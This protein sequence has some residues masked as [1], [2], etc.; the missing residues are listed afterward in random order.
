[1]KHLAAF[2]LASF[3]GVAGCSAQSAEV[4]PPS[5]GLAPGT[6]TDPLAAFGAEV[7]PC[8]RLQLDGFPTNITRPSL[9]Y[10]QGPWCARINTAQVYVWAYARDMSAG[11]SEQTVTTNVARDVEQ[12]YRDL[13][14]QGYRQVC[15]EVRDGQAVDVGLERLGEPNMV[16]LSAVGQVGS[17]DQPLS[18]VV[19]VSPAMNYPEVIEGA[20]VIP[21]TD[22]L[23][24]AS[25]TTASDQ[26]AGAAQ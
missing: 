16:R 13:T 11:V 17:T 10:Y 9:A 1:V 22:G 18:L 3:I 20:P 6:A 8:T 14:A 25:M 19:T 15:G 26:V 4:Q 2:L 5:P 12:L 21:C 7:Q 23:T 24:L